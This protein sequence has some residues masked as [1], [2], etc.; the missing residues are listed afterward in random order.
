MSNKKSIM[1]DPLSLL[2]MCKILLV[3]TFT[4]K[5]YKNMLIIKNKHTT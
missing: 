5:T 3:Q 1:I 2:G 4:Y